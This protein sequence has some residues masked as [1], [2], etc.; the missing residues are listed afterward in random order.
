MRR[1][2]FLLL[3]IIAA[4]SKA[5]TQTTIIKHPKTE[6]LITESPITKLITTEVT[7][8]ESIKT[9]A[10]MPEEYDYTKNCSYFQILDGII[11]FI[12]KI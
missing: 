11:L 12:R 10:T 8:A 3:L 5:T 6:A 7:T 1:F 2:S 9:E 4:I